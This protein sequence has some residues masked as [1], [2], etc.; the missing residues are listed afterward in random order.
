VYWSFCVLINTSCLET[1]L[2]PLCCGHCL[3]NV[4][5]THAAV[6][7]RHLPAASERS[8]R[9][10]T[11]AHVDAR[12]YRHPWPRPSTCNRDV[13]FAKRWSVHARL[14]DHVQR[15]NGGMQVWI[16]VDGQCPVSAVRDPSERSNEGNSEER[17]VQ[18]R[19]CSWLAAYAERLTTG[20]FEVTTSRSLSMCT[21]EHPC[22]RPCHGYH[23][24]FCRFIC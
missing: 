7:V 3:C 15:R 19:L 13:R 2:S 23:C 6:I 14:A 22:E 16:S 20:V 4:C 9:R 10:T 18:Q 24:F 12:R 8:R 17:D 11:P 5:G 1:L 21:L